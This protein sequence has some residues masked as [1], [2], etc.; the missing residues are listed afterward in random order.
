MAV[1]GNA[2]KR[3]MLIAV[4]LSL[5]D[6]WTMALKA[7][8]NKLKK[9]AEQPMSSM[10]AQLPASKRGPV[11]PPFGSADP[12]PPDSSG[13]GPA[14]LP[15]V[16]MEGEEAFSNP[17][18]FASWMQ[19][20][21]QCAEYYKQCEVAVAAQ[22]GVEMP[23][24]A[25]SAPSTPYVGT[26]GGAGAPW[27]TND[28]HA[29][30][31]SGQ[32]PP[33][34]ANRTCNTASAYAGMYGSAAAYPPMASQAASLM[35]PAAMLPGAAAGWPAGFHK[36]E[37]KG[38][39]D[40][41]DRKDKKSKKDKKKKKKKSKK[42]K[43]SS[44]SSSSSSSSDSD[45]PEPCFDRTGGLRGTAQAAIAGARGLGGID[46]EALGNLL[47]AWYY[48]GYYTGHFAARQGR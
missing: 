30:A 38:K 15:G 34:A 4:S 22:A 3:A 14:S 28:L 45:D 5:L 41:K 39:K 43:D 27:P 1:E 11:P 40:K 24:S 12:H 42:S 17:E 16:A 13:V 19:Y 8:K 20:Y 29:A 7:E 18:D 36:R 47:M 21:K 44:D 37:D 26:V 25:A 9:T 6:K 48:S 23:P 46:D 2:Q 31:L 32:F 33:A 35:T 10:N